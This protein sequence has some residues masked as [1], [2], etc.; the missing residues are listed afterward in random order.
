MDRIGF[1]NTLIIVV[2]ALLIIA[3]G[4]TS[5][6]SLSKLDETAKTSLISNILSASSYEAEG[7]RNY[8][9]EQAQP[10]V[11]LAELYQSN[12][13]QTDHE[14]YMAFGAKVAGITKLTLGFDDGRSY[15]SAPS[16][17]TFPGGIG[18]P[19]KYDPRTRD[20]YQLG[21]RS[22]GLALS[23]VFYTSKGEPLLL[24]VHPIEGGVLASDVRLNLLKEVLEGVD[25]V[26]GSVGMIVDHNGMVL[27]STTD[28]LSVTE[29]LKDIPELSRFSQS[30]LNR[31]ILVEEMPFNGVDS[32]VVSTR[33]DLEG[34]QPWY[35]ILAADQ[36][37]AFAPVREASWQLILVALMITAA[38]VVILLMVLHHIYRPVIALKGLVASLS[39][40]NGDLTQRLAVTSND[41]LG[42]IATSVN[43]FIENIQ[44]M[45]L[46]IKRVS[47]H[48]S[49]GVLVL[50]GHSDDSAAILDQHQQ[51]TN[52]VVTAVEELSSSAALVA[53]NAQETAQFTQEANQSGELSKETIANA[54]LSLRHLSQQVD[55]STQNVSNM[56][57]ETQNISS[58][59]EVIRA[60]AEQTNLL[61]L[62]AAIEA[63][64]AGEQGRGFAVVADE[65]RALAG[66]TQASTKQIE[67]AMVKL[68][69]E[70]ASVVTSIEHTKNTSE[71]TVKEAEGVSQSLGTM[72]DYVTRINDL[73]TQIASSAQEQ[74]MVIQDIGQNMTHI[75]TM[76]EQLAETGM[77]V[78]NETNHI[79][80]INEQ[81][82]GI[83]GQFK[84]SK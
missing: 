55:S 3:L 59:L 10:I 33:I 80:E 29:H 57:H 8:I 35:L 77:S 5:Y 83:I 51:E 54:Q 72:S 2:T 27:A 18:I 65:V 79:H 60:I 14:K 74:N 68:Q 44:G 22:A 30:I 45:I 43:R 20:W 69:H 61:A 25:V 81:L 63:A 76:V 23:D 67:E 42:D 37:V 50:K 9:H 64:R 21:K 17:S 82:N 73:S 48:L 32:L 7:I 12:N 1:K 40:G 71:Q 62:N 39:S 4:L 24:A 36:A 49:D 28:L 84:L 47:E 66:R 34:S 38:S 31:D 15:S 46:E 78:N 19:S 52:L 75:H 41:D 11:D 58:I 56:S 16:A 6:I 53:E 70:S 26:K 13:Y